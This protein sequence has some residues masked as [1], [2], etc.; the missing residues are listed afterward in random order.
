MVLIGYRGSGKTS[1]GRAVAARLNRAFIDSDEEIVRRAG[2]SIAEIFAAGGEPAFRELE[3]AVVL[4]IAARTDHVIAVGG[5]ALGREQNLAAIQAAG[6][7][8]V[9]LQCHARE[10]HRRIQS[11]PATATARP[12]LSKLGGGIEEIEAILG[13]RHP[14][15][16]RIAAAEVDVTDMTIEQA[17]ERI[18]AIVQSPLIPSP[19]TRGEGKGGGRLSI[20]S[21]QPPPQPS[22]GLPGEG[23]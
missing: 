16:R 2:K 14:L 17:A 21:K 6:H 11:D 3:T 12:A 8:I 13:Q 4:E 15:W 10:L 5:G 9:Y 18:A 19:C 23:E 1:V 7:G 20:E 22:P